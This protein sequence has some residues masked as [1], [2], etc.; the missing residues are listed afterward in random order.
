MNSLKLFL[1]ALFV[2]FSLS[3]Q[4]PAWRENP[5]VFNPSGLEFDSL[6]IDFQ[7]LDWNG[8]QLP[9]LLINED[10][11]FSYYQKTDAASFSWQKRSLSLP[12]LPPSSA[13]QTGWW[14]AHI[15]NF[16]A[17]DMDDDGDW[18]LVTDSLR[19]FRNIG[20]NSDPVW[21]LETSFFDGRIDSIDSL[22][23]RVLCN[24]DFTFF[25]YEGDGDLDLTARYHG[26]GDQSDF[27]S[28]LFLYD[29]ASRRWI[30]TDR[31]KDQVAWIPGSNIHLCDLDR[32]GDPDLFSSAKIIYGTDL[33]NRFSFN[34]YA[35]RGTA[36][37]PL[38][39]PEVFPQEIFERISTRYLISDQFYDIDRDGD[40]DYIFFTP[41]RHLKIWFNETTTRH[42]FVFTDRG[43]R[44]GRLN[45][46]GYAVPALYRPAADDAPILIVSEQY[47]NWYWA[48][49]MFM[50][51]YGRLVD[52]GVHD[53]FNHDF[54]PRTHPSELAWESFNVFSDFSMTANHDLWIS[55]P[56]NP[57]QC[58]AISYNHYKSWQSLGFV[59]ALYHQESAGDSVIW[60]M[61]STLT[62]FSLSTLRYNRPVLADIDLDGRPEL[63]IRADSVYTCFKNQGRLDAPDWELAADL[64]AGI[65]ALV[66]LNLVATDL[67]MDGDPDLL[68][69]D[70]DGT[71]HYYRNLLPEQP[72]RWAAMP[73]VFAGLDVGQSAAPAIGDINGDGI[74]ELIVGNRNGQLYCYELAEYLRVEKPSIPAGGFHLLP[75]YPNPFNHIMTILC[76]TDQTG[77]LEVA[78]YDAAG[79]LV[80]VLHH[81]DISSGMHKFSWDGSN[82]SGQMAPSGLYF[83]STRNRTTAHFTKAIL[84]K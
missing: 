19:L 80:K 72:L 67:D 7:F 57:V 64:L 20:T 84:L 48:S 34:L 63:F 71:L 32:D 56:E 8:D 1:L 55:F 70:A 43:V 5:A 58:I 76:E 14:F 23:G 79:R 35:N 65:D 51:A 60:K 77:W 27:Y 53:L 78:V 45:V 40:Q 38:Y 42:T 31:F 52:L 37:A 36:A 75:A 12:N 46:P 68:F 82:R 33:I 62:E 21:L 29:T 73:E 28:F 30:F 17:A 59:V 11:I 66:H 4:P 3:A 41:N 10:G 74:L 49:D 39:T 81:G 61:D 18:D 69:G 24:D 2:P 47:D 83:V 6:A 15:P 25:D 26:P 50:H 16:C 22:Y 54:S 9:D 44:L 13:H